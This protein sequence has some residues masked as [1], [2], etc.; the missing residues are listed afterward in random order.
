M[1]IATTILF[2]IAYS[3]NKRAEFTALLFAILSVILN[4]NSNAI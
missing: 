3:I 4:V 2:N 1:K